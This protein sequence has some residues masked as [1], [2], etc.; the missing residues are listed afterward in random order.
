MHTLTNLTSSTD[1]F[2]NYKKLLRIELRSWKIW[3]RKKC[4]LDSILRLR[5]LEPRQNYKHKSTKIEHKLS[6]LKKILTCVTSTSK[7]KTNK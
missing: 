5:L 2:R 3:L 4:K 6:N 7:A 1:R